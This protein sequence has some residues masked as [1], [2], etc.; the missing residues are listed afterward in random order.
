MKRVLAKIAEGP[1]PAVRATLWLLWNAHNPKAEAM[2]RLLANGPA[3]S[4]AT[5]E[6][7]TT[8]KRLSEE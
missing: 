7:K 4:W 6:A 1:P 3:D 5:K 2:L 8:L